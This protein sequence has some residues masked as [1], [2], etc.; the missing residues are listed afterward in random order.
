[1]LPA[2]RCRVGISVTSWRQERS[3]NIT[4]P[5]LLFQ[6]MQPWFLLLA[7]R[8]V[9]I[10]LSKCAVPSVWL[11]CSMLGV[12]TPA[13]RNPRAAF[14]PLVITYM[15][16]NGK[17]GTSVVCWFTQMASFLWWCFYFPFFLPPPLAE[18]RG[19]TERRLR[20]FIQAIH[21]LSALQLRITWIGARGSVTV[22]L[23]TQI[24]GI[25]GV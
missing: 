13:S 17:N 8:S 21:I 6:E 24:F 4:C 2:G 7:R 1:M 10:P 11:L 25:Q 19:L 9:L 18:A 3:A 20:K 5:P 22:L 16:F 12:I 15:A 23:G 14:H